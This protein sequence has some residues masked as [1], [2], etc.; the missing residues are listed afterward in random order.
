MWLHVNDLSEVK[1]LY[2]SVMPEFDRNETLLREFPDQYRAF[3]FYSSRESDIRATLYK[4]RPLAFAVICDLP[5]TQTLVID[6]FALDISVRKK[7]YARQIFWN[8]IVRL[9]YLWPEIKDYCNRWIL[10]AYIHNVEPW[11]KIMIMTPVDTKIKSMYLD[12]PI[13]LLQHNVIDAENAY[14]EWHE[15]QLKWYNSNK[16]KKIA[17]L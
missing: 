4:S 11:C 14:K 13:K 16:T 17:K 9:P 10:E 7:G 12:R 1:D 6:L 8:L 2:Y 5:K 15:F 3:C